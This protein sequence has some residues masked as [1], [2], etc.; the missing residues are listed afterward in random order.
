VVVASPTGVGCIVA[1]G[2]NWEGLAPGDASAEA[3]TSYRAARP[4]VTSGDF[5]AGRIAPR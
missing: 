2:T 4:V 1:D 5:G 3:W